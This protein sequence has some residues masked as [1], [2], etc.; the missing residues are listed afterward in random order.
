[1][2]Q[3]IPNWQQDLGLEKRLLHVFLASANEVG[4]RRDVT[5]TITLFVL[6]QIYI[7]TSAFIG[8]VPLSGLLVAKWMQTLAGLM[9]G[10]VG[11]IL[12]FLIAGFSIFATM[13]KPEL[14]R[15]LAQIRVEGRRI[16]EFKFIFFN[17]IYI[18]IMYVSYIFILLGILVGFTEGPVLDF[19]IIVAIRIPVYVRKF[20]IYEAAIIF[21]SCAAFSVLLLKSF[22]WNLYQSLLIVIFA[23]RHD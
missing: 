15:T 9:L 23:P 7:F 13:A 11:S 6:L 17:F 16:S 20:L 14:F 1:M 8:H 10:F 18:F 3:P 4:K 2:I 21:I 12:G 22:I 19:I 5:I